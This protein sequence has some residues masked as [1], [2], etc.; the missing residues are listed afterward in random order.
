MLGTQYV[1]SLEL[2]TMNSKMNKNNPYSKVLTVAY[3]VKALSY[4]TSTLL[5]T[6]MGIA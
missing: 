3:K 4:E 6:D 2:S 5:G 1:Q